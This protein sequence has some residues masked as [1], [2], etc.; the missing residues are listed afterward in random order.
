MSDSIFSGLMS[1]N[2]ETS[3]TALESTRD[4]DV[5]NILYVQNIPN[6]PDSHKTALYANVKSI[7]T[8][9]AWELTR[10]EG[11]VKAKVDDKKLPSDDSVASKSKRTAYR[12]KVVDSY[13]GQSP[14]L[15]N[16]TVSTQTTKVTAT[17][18]KISLTVLHALL[19]IVKVSQNP[20]LSNVVKA[21]GLGFAAGT[22]NNVQPYVWYIIDHQLD[23]VRR[24]LEAV[25]KTFTFSVTITEAA[26]S[27]NAVSA[28]KEKT[29]EASI[30]YSHSAVQFNFG[31]WNSNA[32]Q[33]DEQ[34]A[35]G[36]ELL[37]QKQ[38]NL[39]EI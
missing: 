11:Q 2:A 6:V 16:V 14:W 5:A 29:Y 23:P 32:P 17:E 27:T 35:L 33:D 39:L 9:V 31:L 8:W 15:S 38:L 36:K 30:N 24:T 25:I 22:G 3:K 19:G 10:V 18:D 7:T 4:L 13:R 28:S 34:L 37:S 21:L 12:A 1:G 20:Q 26:A